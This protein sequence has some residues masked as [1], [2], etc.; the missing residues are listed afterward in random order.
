M[1]ALLEPMPMWLNF[2][3]MFA[4]ILV[5]TLLALVWAVKFRRRRRRKHRYHRHHDRHHDPRGERKSNPTLAE[6]G[7][8]PPLRPTD[9]SSDQPPPP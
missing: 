7:G 1:L 6:R 4:A 8:L 9:P 2:L 3:V 5:G